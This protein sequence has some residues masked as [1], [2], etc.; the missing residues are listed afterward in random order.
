MDEIIVYTCGE[1]KFKAVEELSKPHQP[2]QFP[3]EI[4]KKCN[5]VTVYY[6]EEKK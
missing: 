1:V 5:S 6:G 3:S 4:L 2:H